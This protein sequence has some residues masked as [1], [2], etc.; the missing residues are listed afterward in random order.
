MR[1]D[2]ILVA[3]ISLTH[4]SAVNSVASI[5]V[6]VVLWKTTRCSAMANEINAEPTS[7]FTELEGVALLH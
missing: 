1:T 4:T 3:L 6:G 5:P 7:T 2:D